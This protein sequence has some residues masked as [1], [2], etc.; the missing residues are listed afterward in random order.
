MQLNEEE[1]EQQILYNLMLLEIGRMVVTHF[2]SQSFASLVSQEHQIHRTTGTKVLKEAIQAQCVRL[3]EKI[4]LQFL[5]N[6]QSQIYFTLQHVFAKDSIPVD[7]EG[8]EQAESDAEKVA[9]A[10]EQW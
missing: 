4:Y 9:K 6:L 10:I 2:E 7:F 8:G 1:L 5:S 3:Y